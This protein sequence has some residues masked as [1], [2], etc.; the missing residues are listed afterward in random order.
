MNIILWELSLN[1]PPNLNLNMIDH[2]SSHCLHSEKFM[3]YYSENNHL[4]VICISGFDRATR[5]TGSLCCQLQHPSY[6]SF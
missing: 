5:I 4:N 2:S 1:S 3:K 6:V